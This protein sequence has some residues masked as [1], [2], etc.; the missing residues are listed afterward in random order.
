MT[1][2]SSRQYSTNDLTLTQALYFLQSLGDITH[3]VGFVLIGSDDSIG[4]G[5]FCS[6]GKLSRD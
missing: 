3:D 1:T 2:T 4:E 6:T 5:G